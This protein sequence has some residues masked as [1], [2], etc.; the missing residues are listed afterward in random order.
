M[1][2]ECSLVLCWNARHR[3]HA[4]T[5]VNGLN[6]VARPSFWDIRLKDSNDVASEVLASGSTEQVARYGVRKK[7]EGRACE[8][9]CTSFATFVKKVSC[10]GTA[11]PVRLVRR[12]ERCLCAHL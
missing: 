5:L 11:S 6:A 3:T 12:R 7:N 9:T 8:R 4:F 2:S 10:G 1:C